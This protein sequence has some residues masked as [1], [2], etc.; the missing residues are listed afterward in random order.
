MARDDRFDVR[1]EILRLLLQKVARDR[2]PSVAM[3]NQIEQLLSSPD[4][5]EKYVRVLMDKIE[6]ER[7]PSID[8]LNRVLAQA[9]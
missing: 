4:D 9:A 8:M 6:T 7:F 5:V 2:H 1:R 3:L